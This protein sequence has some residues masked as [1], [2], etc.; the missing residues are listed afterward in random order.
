LG[1]GANSAIFSV[2][3][4]VLLEPLPYAEPGALVRVGVRNDDQDFASAISIADVVA[5][6]DARSFAEFGAWG[7][8]QGGFAAVVNGEVESVPGALAMAGLFRALGV[9]PLHGRAF[10]DDDHEPGAP[11]VVLLAHAYWQER[12]GGDAGVIGRA[13]QLDGQPYTV[14]GVMPAGFQLPGA[15]QLRGSAGGAH[16][17][18]APPM[19]EPEWRAPFWLRGVARLRSADDLVATRT[20]LDR[21][22]EIVMARYPGSAG[23]WSYDIEPLKDT[24]VRDARLTLLVL[25]V[26]VG[27]VLLIAAANVAN[28]LLSRATSRRPE[29]AV[30]SALGA[31]RGR[32]ARQLLAESLLMASL[33]GV[34]GLALA[35]ACV[36]VLPAIAPGGL[37]RQEEIA[38]DGTV[39]LFA[40]GV[41]LLSS[42][43]VGVLPA[44]R[45][46]RADLIV[47]LREGGRTGEPMGGRGS[48]RSALVVLEFALAVSV[49]VGAG[50]VVNSLA[51]LQRVDSGVRMERL[52]TVQIAI[53]RSRYDEPERVAAFF[54]P[55]VERVRALP[56]V[57]AAGMGMGVPPNRLIMRNPFTPE[58]KVYAP[59]E[60][61]PVAAELIVDPGYFEALG[62]R[63]TRGRLFDE[64][65]RA[66]SEPAIII[67]ETLARMYFP[68]VNPVG[69]TLTTGDPVPDAPRLRIVGVVPPVR[70]AG[71]D[72][73]PEPTLYV[74]YAQNRWW[75]SMYLV[76]R[77]RGEPLELVP[78]VRAAVAGLD[79]L[80]PLREIS[81]VERLA[82][83]SVADPRFRALLLGSFGAISL[84]LACAGIYGV[85]AYDV[86]RRRRETGIRIA[87][88]A[89]RGTI[90]GEIVASGMRLAAIGIGIG[91]VFAAVATRLMRGLLFEVE[92]LDP[93]TFV[94]GVALLVVV[95]VAA[96]AIPA[97]RAARTDP[98]VALRAE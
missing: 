32:L 87:I 8:Q 74:P 91:A 29:L 28:L 16:V 84:L 11:S 77:T 65:D 4:A 89:G 66:D 56:G 69:R 94:A 31:G 71:L 47:R 38:V 1:I 81:T 13:L 43:A 30:R 72:L 97:L 45:A 82:S 21:L 50:L 73:L 63:P 24:L 10:V 95:G 88:G 52:L 41:T 34:L 22:P 25:F 33:G 54:D 36:R 37:P 3:N 15:G 5:L 93:A 67:D 62:I 7:V 78:A 51:R 64:T 20:E 19:E 86:A 12:F 23:G 26:A 53:P 44:L 96:C 58:G 70:Y 60:R 14:V 61:A 2:V 80:V 68:D 98:M 6:R 92:P 49:V 57:L 39:L 17:W 46:A 48:A 9:P 90:V 40:L 79:P 18:V 59:G 27:L 76:A 35:W 42:L 83:E 85:L 75:R 55:L